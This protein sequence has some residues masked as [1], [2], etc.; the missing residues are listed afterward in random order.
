MGIDFG[1]ESC[2]VGLFDLLG[3]PVA[4]AAH[5]YPTTHPHPGWAEQNPYD[6]WQALGRASHDALAAGQIDPADVI[7]VSADATTMTV[8]ASDQEGN[9]LRPAILWM[10]IRAGAQ[11]ERATRS[12]SK[13]RLY[14]AGGTG[15]ASAEWYPFKVAWLKENEP[16]TY[17]AAHMVTDATDWIT[18]K[19]TGAW[20]VSVNAAA[21]RMYY[22]RDLGGWPVDF[23]TELGLGDVFTKLPDTVA[24][25]GAN[26][27]SLSLTAAAHLGLKPGIAVG[28]GPVDSAAGLIG[29]GVVEPGQTALITGS[30]H[31]LFGQSDQPVYGAGFWG[32][33]ADAIIP[34]QYTVEGGQ[35]STGSV[36]KWFKD[37][38][39]RD[40]REQ[41]EREGRSVYDLLN[42]ESA[43]IP[44]GS[45]G[46]IVNEY[47]QGNRT[48]YTDA[49]ARGIIWGLSL[50]HT[51]AHVYH[52]IQEG[53]CYGTAHNLRAMA[54][55]GFS[56][57]QLV[58]SGGMTKSPDLIQLHADVTGLPITLTEVQD[59]PLLG[60]AMCAAVGAGVFP[61]LPAAA[62][63]MVNQ[64]GTIRPDPAR[65]QAYAFYVDAYCSAYPALRSDIHRVVDH[66]AAYLTG[67]GNSRRSS[68]EHGGMQPPTHAGEQAPVR[69]N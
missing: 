58:V 29:L 18:H 46:L 23:Y 17:A 1:T 60:S 11:A 9:P 34:G 37:Q 66:E 49:K 14:N 4:V 16:A 31:A 57:R 26:V 22:N 20:T 15:P 36:M 30:S 3:R 67:D 13:A 56:A 43:A 44:I 63:Q 62:R 33:F 47:F 68:S 53:I 19:L 2:R 8:V 55:A 38:F 35:V 50:A 25:L 7:A 69:L 51:R 21:F 54:A 48:P 10:D 32:G 64:I 39:A 40:V 24:D 5:T 52:A 59:G 42:A 61:D 6:W 27:G 12:T 28:Q 41:A 45:D 65:H